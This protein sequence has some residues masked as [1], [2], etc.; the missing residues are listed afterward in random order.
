MSYRL[1]HFVR[2]QAYVD[3]N[4]TALVRE[5]PFGYGMD[6]TVWQ[7]LRHSV[8]KVFEHAKNYLD[9]LECYRRLA[10]AGVEN[11]SGFAVPGLIDFHDRLKVIELKIVRPPF[12][13]DFGKVYL[14]AP[15]PY[16]NDLEIMGHWHA[17][18]RE[19]SAS[20]GTMC[21]RSSACCKNTA[22]GMSIQSR[23]TSCLAIDDSA[24]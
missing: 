3:H 6:G 17:E 21:Y 22:F 11:L 7:T 2:A 15:P 8:V 23:A 13:L 9:E 20:A 10:D 24:R 12:L 4:K 5:D 16:W 1:S 18:G 14:D 19:T